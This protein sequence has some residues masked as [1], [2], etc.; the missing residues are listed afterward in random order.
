MKQKLYEY[1]WNAFEQ[2][3]THEQ[4]EEKLKE[5]GHDIQEIKKIER[6]VLKDMIS[7]LEA[8]KE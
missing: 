2:E 8:E 4:I 3:F 7:D 6:D 5:L 1:I